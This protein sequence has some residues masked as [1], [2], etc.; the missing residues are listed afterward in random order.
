MVSL[1]GSGFS[2]PP[3][4]FDFSSSNRDGTRTPSNGRR[5]LSHWATSEVPMSH[6]YDKTNPV[7]SCLQIILAKDLFAGNKYSILD[8]QTEAGGCSLKF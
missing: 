6:A 4:M 7:P 3:G 2:G 5:S 1:L 8:Y